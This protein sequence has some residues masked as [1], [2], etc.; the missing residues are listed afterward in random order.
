YID[1]TPIYHSTATNLFNYVGYKNSE[2]DRLIEKGR[3]ELNPE[4]AAVIW[5]ELQEIIYRDQPYTYLF[6]Q[7]KVVAVNQK[8]RNVTPVMLSSFYNLENWSK[9]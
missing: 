4:K 2:A 5:K 8:F 1:P 7:N 3:S 6:W 9:I